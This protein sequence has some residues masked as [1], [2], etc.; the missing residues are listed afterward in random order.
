MAF[1]PALLSPVEQP[2]QSGFDPSLLTPVEDHG[3]IGPAPAPGLGQ[4]LMNYL[5]SQ[6]PQSPLYNIGQSLSQV[7]GVAQGLAS[8][9]SSIQNMEPSPTKA[10]LEQ[11]TLPNIALAAVGG[12]GFKAGMA[13]PLGRKILA[14]TL[15][16]FGAQGVQGLEQGVQQAKTD[17]A[18][19]YDEAGYR[20]VQGV[21]NALPALGVTA[22][23]SLVPGTPY[24]MRNQ[25]AI[26]PR[27]LHSGEEGYL[28]SINAQLQGSKATDTTIPSANFS[29]PVQEVPQQ[30]KPTATS[31][32]D[33]QPANMPLGQGFQ[34]PAGT[35]VPV[36]SIRPAVKIG[37]MVIPIEGHATMDA[38]RVANANPG[39]TIVKGY[40][41]A[42]G[43]F[44]G[45]NP[46][47]AVR[48]LAQQKEQA[49]ANQS[50]VST[51][52]PGQAQPI[53]EK[54]GQEKGQGSVGQ[55]QVPSAPQGEVPGNVG[56]GLRQ[57]GGSNVQSQRDAGGLTVNEQS[58]LKNLLA[59]P[60]VNRNEWQSG[61]IGKLQGKQG[62]ISPKMGGQTGEAGFF[63]LFGGADLS[64]LG[65]KQ[66]AKVQGEQ[67][68]NRMKNVL[69]AGSAAWD[70]MDK[71]GL[72][73]FLQTPHTV[74]EVEEWLGSVAPKVELHSYGMEGKVSEAKNR[75]DQA[76]GELDKL[77]YHLDSDGRLTRRGNDFT[78]DNDN[79]NITPEMR[80][81][82]QQGRDN[83][84]QA[85]ADAS[86]KATSYYHQ[87]SAL[88]TDE[89]MPEWTKTKSGNNVQRVDVVVPQKTQVKATGG[90]PEVKEKALWQPDN[91]HENLPNTLGWAMIQYKTGPKGEKIAV[92]AEAQSRWGQEVRNRKGTVM[93]TTPKGQTLDHP[94][95][96]DYNR[97]I[98]KAAIDQARKEGATHIMVSDG[99]TAMMTEGHDKYVSNHVPDIAQEK[100]MRL[101]YD[102]VLPKIAEEL[103]GSK[104][105][106]VSVGEHKN[107]FTDRESNAG[108]EMSTE[109]GG[110]IKEPRNN[111]IFR[112][113]D[114]TPKT[115]VSGRMYPI[116]KVDTQNFSLMEKDK[117]KSPVQTLDKTS[118]KMT[119][120]SGSII[121]PA[122]A[123]KEGVE[124][125][126]TVALS[127]LDSLK[128]TGKDIVDAVTSPA[129]WKTAKLAHEGY[130][131]PAT[132]AR[133]PQ[134]ANRMAA[135]GNSGTAALL[136]ANAEISKVLGDKLGD[137]QFRKQMGG[138]IYEDMRQAENAPGTPVWELRNSPF[139]DEAQLRAAMKNPRMQDAIS[140]WKALIQPVAAEMHQKLGGSMS[141][142]G[143]ETGAFANL[144]AVLEDKPAESGTALSYKVAGETKIAPGS[145]PL[146]TMKRGS[147]F[148]RE[149]KFSGEEYNL[150]AKDMAQRMMT[151]NASEY[152]KRLLYDDLESTGMGK[153]VEKK[154]DAPEGMVV[155]DNPVNLRTFTMKDADGATKTV[156]QNKWLAVDPGIKTEVQ[157][158]MQL[159]TNWKQYLKDQHPWVA[160]A[161]QVAIKAQV[162][163]GIDLGFHTFNDMVAVAN[164]GKG[165]LDLPAKV[166]SAIQV[167]SDLIRKDPKIQ[168]ELAKM[169]EAGVT[170]RG[171]SMGGWSSKFLKTA[172][173]I[174]RVVLNRE[175]QD[176][177]DEKRAVDSPAE[178]RR[179][180][181][182][183]AGQYNKRF[184]G[185]LQ[186]GMQETGLGSFNVAGR[187]FNRLAIHNLTADPGVK[188]TSKVEA[189]RMRLSIATGIATAALVAPAVINKQTTGEYQPEGTEFGD[190]VV[191]KNADGSYK[192]LNMRKWTMLDRGGRASGM[193]AVMREQVLPRIRGEVPAT[194]GHTAR[195]AGK[196]ILRTAVAPFSGPPVNVLSVLGTGKTEG[197][198]GYDQRSPGDKGAPYVRAAVGALNPLAGPVATGTSKG[199]VMSHIG[200]RLGSI[201]GVGNAQSALSQIRQKAAQ[202][203]QAHNIKQN[204]ATFAPSEYEPLKQA[205]ANNDIEKAKQVY[206][207]LLSEKA[208]EHQSLS[209]EDA[210]DKAQKMIQGEF[211]KMENFRFVT[212]ED[213]DLFKASL[214]PKQRALYDKA[215]QQQKD[216]AE[217]FFDQIQPKIEK[218]PF[219]IRSPKGFNKY[220]KGDSVSRGGQQYTVVDFDKDGQPLVEPA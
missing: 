136:R 192:V 30:N 50:S 54:V 110:Q 99:E 91:L 90:W 187:N 142:S 167:R 100:G 148:S 42:D 207:Q 111:L 34:T 129:A 109:E 47:A 102:T 150:D 72:R 153:L 69:G 67:M 149:R 63:R 43:Q 5:G 12:P 2:K 190:V 143:K 8:T 159:N 154:T 4:R 71:A 37:D 95:L 171:E 20:T 170:F 56:Q 185:Y 189:L 32:P 25:Q 45:N 61:Q 216:T 27:V 208:N 198:Y 118:G 15:A 128:A 174:T 180:I 219:P 125:L 114:G 165:L 152:Q 122:T 17:P 97:L 166:K 217:K 220:N 160:N 52:S 151:K 36:P 70:V 21:M 133:S 38:Q 202:Y 213:E 1:D 172:D 94:L 18:Q 196:D 80:K 16:G 35:P 191:G 209:D 31:I 51:S 161:S 68:Y 40:V 62:G 66:D 182:A 41:T 188:A 197:G 115:D 86:V 211:S 57:S 194:L 164:S 120:Q 7:P 92:I 75:Y 176:M 116:D 138:I 121:N 183:R 24:S 139:A 162:G 14:G 178:R 26:A 10:V 82:V 60:E 76:V 117:A 155:L 212:K 163:L 79:P 108:R 144:I 88:P 214:T 87:V 215:V 22:G 126:T 203:K 140:K 193:G 201:V 107:A 46:L 204:D 175:Y 78:W 85:K 104:G 137:E 29:R 200:Q 89:P 77:G 83:A 84:V 103:T 93:E 132:E 186:Q 3:S 96:R 65:I 44:L 48:A 64:R 157:Q 218:N 127:K 147:A 101:N 124:K 39:K 131:F 59:I 199:D 158:L 179:Y 113:A 106:R 177:V 206:T 123:I 49:N 173:N 6:P 9:P 98:L 156:S 145:G 210:K 11:L 19:S 73:T 58:Q 53:V 81:W 33:T 13:S 141:E 184:M 55:E 195:A 74:K 23:S 169:A 119:S 146:A 205:L 112:N 168:E 130:D 105:E 181:N 135:F 134:L 28:D